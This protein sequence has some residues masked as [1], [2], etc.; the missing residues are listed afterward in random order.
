MIPNLLHFIYLGGLPF[1]F[2]HWMAIQSAVVLNRPER[3][4]LHCSGEP[5]GPYWQR[6]RPVV[7]LVPTKPVTRV[8]G[9]RL[10]KITH[11]ADVLRL[12]ILLEYGGIYLDLDTISVQPLSHLLEHPCVLGAELDPDGQDGRL[13]LGNAVILAEKES[14]FI[15][16]W[17]RHYAD[18]D[19]TQREVHAK[20]LP[21]VLALRYPDQIHVEPYDRFYDPPDD[22]EGLAR[23]FEK[24]E[25]LPKGAVQHLW[26]R[27]SWKQYLQHIDDQAVR[28]HR[29]TYNLIARRFLD[30]MPQVNPAPPRTSHAERKPEPVKIAF[31]FLTRDNLTQP[32]LWQA[33]FD[34]APPD[35][36]AVYCHPKNPQEVTDSVLRDSIIDGL[37]PTQHGHVSLVKASL[38][39]FTEA[40]QRDLNITHFV[41]VSESTIPILPFSEIHAE[42]SQLGA[43]SLLRWYI[44]RQGTVHFERLRFA[45]NPRAFRKFYWHDQWIVAC[46]NHVVAL[47]SQPYLD[48]FETMIAADE[49]YFMNVL[50]N[51]LDF[52]EGDFVQRWTTFVNWRDTEENS[53]HEIIEYNQRTFVME[54]NLLS[55]KTYDALNFKHLTAAREGRC[56]F[57][58][59]ISASCDC[60]SLID[61]VRGL[62]SPDGRPAA[63]QMDT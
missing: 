40:S 61:E 52:P 1:S 7:T 15:R 59:K 14:A 12:R 26:Q 44:P 42:L 37:I 20:K 30:Q 33:F 6:I 3:V 10:N 51:L 48:D 46:R 63:H 29:T 23:L 16:E 18:F 32:Q 28:Q 60:S 22:P 62:G 45:R 21:M 17:Y 5:S 31:C 56:W 36:Y 35:Q 9:R 34:A 25:D 57:F 54:G 53:T 39:L 58:R 49:H 2:V 8:F 4:Y 27:Q 41:L 47:E 24:V 43:S 50:V 55:P 13:T 11:Q 19:P 38:R